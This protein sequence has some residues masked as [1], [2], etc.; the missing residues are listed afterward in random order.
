METFVLPVQV[1]WSDLDPN[2]HL[3]HSVFYDWGALSRIEFLNGHGLTAEVM[4]S[5]HFGPIIFREECIFK[6]EIRSGDKVTIDLELL[7]SRRDHSRWTIRHTIMKNENILSA[8]LTIDG[9]W[10]DTI[11]RKLAKP[12]IEFV[13][14][15]EI[16]PMGKDFEWTDQ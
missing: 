1:R 6:K 2:F 9:A 4:G 15:F 8:I 11:Q 13:R 16:M 3:R 12:P 10:I 5:H 14:V 7:K